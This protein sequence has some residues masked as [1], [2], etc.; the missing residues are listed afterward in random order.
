[1]R[2]TVCCTCVSG[3]TPEPESDTDSVEDVLVAS[4]SVPLDVPVLEGA[5]ITCNVVLAPDFKSIGNV[6]GARANPAPFRLAESMAAVLL[7]EFVTVTDC[8]PD[9]PTAT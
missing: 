4:D 8:A 1:M 3:A 9:A 5:K 6:V 2:V 7:D